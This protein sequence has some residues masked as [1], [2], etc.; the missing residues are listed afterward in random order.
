MKIDDAPR[1]L[2]ILFTLVLCLGAYANAQEQRGISETDLNP[3]VNNGD[4]ERETSVPNLQRIALEGTVDPKDYFVGPS[5]VLAV[6]ISSVSLATYTL[7]VTPEGTLIIPTV[8]E[9]SVANHTLAETKTIVL[10]AIRRK[11]TSGSATVTLLVP[12]PIVVMV[13]GHVLNPGLYELSAVSRANQALELANSPRRDQTPTE[14]GDMLREGGTRNIV[15]KHRD[16]SD[17]RVD[18]VRFM[19]VNDG[20]W[21]PFLREG[22]IVVVP[23]RDPSRHVIAVYGEVNSPGRYEFVEGD[24]LKDAINIAH[25]F[26][27]WALKDSIEFFRLARNGALMEKKVVSWTSVVAGYEENPRLQPGDRILVKAS[28]DLREDYRVTIAGEVLFPGV[29]P[30]TKNSSRLSELLNRA[31]GV[32]EFASLR[33]AELS[34]R[35]I[36]PE[37][38]DYERRVSLRGGTTAEDSAYFVLETDLR[39]RKERVNVDFERL[40]V[41]G[42]S[43]QDIILQTDDYINVP[44]RRQTIYVYGQV[45]S[46]GHVPFNPQLDVADYIGQA[47]GFTDDARPDDLR[48][49]KASTRQW[50]ARSE[51]EIEAGDYIWV[52][53]KA[54]RSFAYYMTVFSQ[55]AAVLSVVIGIAVLVAQAGK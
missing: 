12:R 20:K 30:I 34:R 50:L 29:Y 25:G 19:A 17:S 44:S 53:R 2:H 39:I 5:D 52:P 40:L 23:R 54:D 49:I 14:S 24:S 48:I 18:L 26:T 41:G 32:T 35:S 47:G 42:D 36:S 22:D 55:G 16:G 33:T 37:E 45:V 13:T 31:G 7:V 3:R 8:G 11:Y 4:R 43:T 46:P 6:G 15:L 9:V 51:T 1:T 21:N 27:R 28:Q 10:S 38:L